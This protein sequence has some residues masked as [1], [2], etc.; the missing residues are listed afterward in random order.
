MLRAGIGSHI[1]KESKGQSVLVPPRPMANVTDQLA[2]KSLTRRSN[3]AETQQNMTRRR[4]KH[5]AQGRL[6]EA[7]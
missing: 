2:S 7:L 5:E 4:G 6:L 3:Q 1:E